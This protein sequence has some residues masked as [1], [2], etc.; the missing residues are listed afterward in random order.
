M[1]DDQQSAAAAD[2]LLERLAPK[3]SAL[4]AGRWSEGQVSGWYEERPW[5]CGFNFL[6]SS[7][8]NFVE[9]WQAQTFDL[10]TIERELGWAAGVGFNALR[11]N[12]PFAVW[13]ADPAGLIERIDSFLGV[14]R[15]HGLGVTLCLFDDCGFSGSETAA[16][17]QPDPIPGVHNSRAVASPGRNLVMDR[18]TWPRLQS[19]VDSVLRRFAADERVLVWDLYN[20]PGNLMIFLPGGLRSFDPALEAMSHALMVEAFGWARK[21]APS[22]PL[23]VGAWHLSMPWEDGEVAM[24]DHAIDR[25]ALLLSDVTSFHAYC[26]KDRLVAVLDKLQ[27]TGRPLMCTEWMARTIGSRIE[28]QLPIFHQRRVGAWQWGLVRGR[29]QTH[30]PWPMVSG[31]ASDHDDEWFHDMLWPDGLPY[32]ASEAQLVRQLMSGAV[33]S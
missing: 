31:Q 32:R 8:V 28:Q 23:T 30:L 5:S 22:Q 4:S 9:M 2:R 18:S 3:I 17:R 24:Y 33:A 13:E 20:E 29:T 14:A 26:D 7:A 10:Q 1:T 21:V 15:G 19:Y 27:A 25:T 6:P 11:T 12:L 16:G